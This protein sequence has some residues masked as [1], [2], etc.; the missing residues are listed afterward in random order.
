ML[1]KLPTELLAQVLEYALIQPYPVQMAWPIPRLTSTFRTRVIVLRRNLALL[2]VNRSI[3]TM[4][5]PI[6]WGK[7]EFFHDETE[8]VYVPVTTAKGWPS[9]E[10]AVRPCTPMP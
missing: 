6:F 7:I 2:A 10:Q 1:L 4:A 3:R 8:W 5:L 9:I